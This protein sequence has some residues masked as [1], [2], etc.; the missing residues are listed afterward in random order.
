M[1]RITIEISES[2]KNHFSQLTHNSNETLDHHILQ[3]SLLKIKSLSGNSHDDI[4]LS[5]LKDLETMIHMLMEPQWQVSAGK[6]QRINATMTYF[7]NEN[8]IIPDSTPGLGF[9]DDCI[10]ISNTKEELSHELN[11]YLDFQG[12]RR[13]YGQQKCV[14][15]EDWQEIKKQET[16]SR[17]RHR[18]TRLAM[19]NRRG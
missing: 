19:K 7:L 18:R 11:D 10:V 13:V 14:N 16:A 9:L 2:L 12:T 17:L 6:A 3:R 8:D 1:H 15:R 5:H 4:L